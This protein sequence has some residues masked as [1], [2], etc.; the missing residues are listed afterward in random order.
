MGFRAWGL[1]C[2]VEALGLELR[3]YLGILGSDCGPVTLTLYIVWGI[4][5]P[6]RIQALAKLLKC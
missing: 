5:S 4:S 1:V 2:R 3:V 6:S